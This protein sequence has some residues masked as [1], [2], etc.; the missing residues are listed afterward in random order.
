MRSLC[1]FL[2]LSV[3]ASVSAQ[4]ADVVRVRLFGNGAPSEV[5]VGGP[6]RVR[7]DGVDVGGTTGTV[8]VARDGAGVRV[9]GPG[10]AGAGRSVEVD[11]G[12]GTLHVVGGR[13]SVDVHGRL[14]AQTVGSQ[15]VAVNHVPM[16]D[17]VASVVG[18]EYGFS[19]IEG[20]KAQAVLVR[21]YA[22][23]ARNPLRPY[24]LDDHQGSQVYRG[25]AAVTPTTERAERENERA[26][27]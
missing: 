12:G 2:L 25:V 22:V 18:S 9:S 6:A 14:V 3:A 24:D 4:D 19:E 1:L 23:R 16:P 7:V 8:V 11:P 13:T 15:L 27:S 26:S 21:T 17:Y 10:V 5:T 20:V